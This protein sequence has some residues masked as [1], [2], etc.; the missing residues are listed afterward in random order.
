MIPLIAGRRSQGGKALNWE[1]KAFNELTADHLYQILRIRSEVF[2]VEQQC[3]YLDCDGKDRH[4]LH[5]SLMDHG[6]IIAYAR[7]LKKGISY[8]EASIGRVLVRPSHRGQGLSRE[9]MLRAIGFI[10][11]G[12]GEKTI[13]IQAQA[14][15]AGFYRSL[16]F[17]EVSDVYM[18]DSIPH[19][20]MIYR[21]QDHAVGTA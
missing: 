10:D 12:F 13:R 19:V 14:Y 11:T 4:A 21:K 3:V 16:G 17:R 20:D 8:D 15:L 5:L 2:V 1:L 6:E 18:E 7:I 9:L